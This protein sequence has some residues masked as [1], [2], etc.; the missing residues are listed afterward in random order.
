MSGCT[1]KKMLDG[2]KHARTL[3]VQNSVFTLHTTGIEDLPSLNFR[4][5]AIE[6]GF[7]PNT[8]VG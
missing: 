1:A 3:E 8:S 4:D 7:T 6:L 5:F 2:R